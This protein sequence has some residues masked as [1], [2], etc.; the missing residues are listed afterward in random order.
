VVS[1]ADLHRKVCS[2]LRDTPPSYWTVRRAAG[3]TR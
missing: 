1:D 3:R 2:I